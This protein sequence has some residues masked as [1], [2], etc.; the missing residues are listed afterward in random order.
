MTAKGYI[1]WPPA[2]NPSNSK[3]PPNNFR[4]NLTQINKGKHSNGNGKNVV[5]KNQKHKN[6]NSNHSK[7]RNKNNNRNHK[8][9]F[10]NG[11]NNEKAWKTRPPTRDKLERCVG[12]ILICV[13]EVGGKVYQW[14]QKCGE[15]RKWVLSHNTS[16]HQDNFKHK[17]RNGNNQRNGVQANIGEGL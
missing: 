2:C 14:C 13:Q 8:K 5:R 9:K 1:R 10:N 6:G 7:N 3:V 17:K 4:A 11:R 12:S 15:N 16:T